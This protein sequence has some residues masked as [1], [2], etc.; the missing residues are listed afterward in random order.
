MERIRITIYSLLIT[1]ALVCA[2]AP[3]SAQT[4][5][6]CSDP[7]VLGPNYSATITTA[8]TKWYVANTFDLPLAI[9]F[10]PT[11]ASQAAPELYLDFSCTPGEY[12][13]PIICSLFCSSNSAYIQ[14]PY[15]Q[16][17]SMSYDEQG[18]A[19]YLVEFGQFYRDMLLAQGIDYNVPVYIRVEFSGAG[20]LTMEPDA[21]SSCMDGPKFMHLGDTVQVQ[22]NDRDRHVIVPYIQ[23]QYDSIRYV[24]QGTQPCTMAVGNKCGFDPTGT[25]AMIIDQVTIQPGGM[26]KV[27]SA[28]LMQYVSDQ[29]NFPNDAGMYFAKFYSTAPGV[30]KIEKIPAPP[31]AGGATLLKYGTK[32]NVFRNDT[33]KV[34]AMPSSWVKAM[35]F[36]TPTDRVFKMYLGTTPDFYL[37][38]AFASYQFDKTDTGHELSLFDADMNEIQ[39]HRRNGD[40]YLY[41]RFE[42]T[43]NTTILPML[44]TP[45]D[46]VTKATR[47]QL[48]KQFDVAAK[49]KVIY[50]LYYE[51]LRGGDLS[52]AWTSTQSACPFYIADTCDVPNSNAAP[53]FYAG[54]VPKKG[55]ATVPQTTVDSWTSYVDPDGYLYIRFYPQGKAKMTVTTT[56][57]EETD[58]PCA[59]VDSILNVTAWDSYTWR[60]TTYTESGNYSKDGT[61]DAE[62]GCLDSVYTLNLTIHTTSYDVIP[63]NGCGNVEYNNKVYSE[64]G[65]YPDTLYDVNGN[66]TI[67]TLNVSV[68]QPSASDTTAVA[69]ESFTWYGTPLTASGDYTH[70]LTNAAG[71]DSTL[72]LHLTINQPTSGD[73]TAVACESFT[74]YGTPLTTSG[75]YTHMLTNAAGC[76]STL[77]LHLTVNHA[78]AGDTTAVACD[79]F[80]WY[81]TPYNTSGD[82]THTLTNA[83]GCDSTLTL[84]LTVNHATAGDT[85]A[86]ACETF[87]WYGTPLTTSGDYTYML[88]NAM[89]CDST[90]TLHLT[91][92]QPT[93]GDTTAVACES[94]TWY[95]TPLTISGDYTHMLTNAA[96]CDSTLTLHLTINH[97]SSSEEARM[98]CSSYEWNGQTYTSSGDYSFQTTNVAGCDSTATLHLT[99][100]QP[101]ASEETRTECGSYE[102]NGQTYT[103][104]GNYVIRTTNMVGCDSTATLHLTIS[105]PTTSEETKTVCNALEWNGKIYTESGNY[106]F[107]TTNVAGCDSMVTLHLTINECAVSYDTVY[108]CN[109]L[110]TEHDEAI[111]EDVVRRYR[112]YLY[113]SPA[114]WDYME[115]VYIREEDSGSLLDLHRAEQNLYAHYVDGLEPVLSIYWSYRP[116]GESA[117]QPLTIEPEAQWVEAGVVA[118]QVQ[119]LCGHAYRSNITTDMEVVNASQES[120]KKVLENGQIII[121]RGGVKYTVLGTKIY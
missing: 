84:H 5:A 47:I 71:C 21:F 8:G 65:Q 80:T 75:D 60:G 33:S 120:G 20:R 26:A 70:M 4:G 31:P 50:S 15:H 12:D 109:G 105:Q 54:S 101:T 56:A 77:T 87:T 61:V 93:A 121:L 67:L 91:I 24:W 79:S 38:D 35:Q 115:G 74:W 3:A 30:M 6:S 72:T 68:Y 55:T 32:S 111:T 48:G 95:G 85:T 36:Y 34:Y 58:P 37:K 73:T 116:A 78:T 7:I 40:N 13:D 42:C 103:T 46:C 100:N 45:S 9:A 17:P 119:F 102:W 113:E 110:N 29:K 39:S 49:S 51:E 43:D 27:S 66:R 114:E 62:T 96:G 89:G 59:T 11:N 112:A 18:K 10:Y 63:L 88:T 25:D 14:M 44:W 28:L 99:I 57:P 117:Y 53:V 90:L 81:G 23:W 69:C 64:S 2:G 86:V 108:F 1:L 118:L 106:V 94:F 52:L 98:E 16:T 19:R 83:A 76:D 104:S 22:A 41:V 82:Y 92:N 97:P 107:K